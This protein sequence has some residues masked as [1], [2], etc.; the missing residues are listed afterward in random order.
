M[1][2]PLAATRVRSQCSL[3]GSSGPHCAPHDMAWAALPTPRAHDRCRHERCGWL[4]RHSCVVWCVLCG[5][6]AFDACNAAPTLCVARRHNG[7]RR[8][9]CCGCSGSHNW[10]RGPRARDTPCITIWQRRACHLQGSHDRSDDQCGR[11]S[12][13]HW[14]VWA[15][16]HVCGRQAASGATNNPARPPPSRGVR[17]GER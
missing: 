17:C 11:H 16:I 8:M 6:C 1:Q 9:T 14:C 5:G 7:Q 15:P 3:C 4:S 12:V 13:C 10:Y 2:P